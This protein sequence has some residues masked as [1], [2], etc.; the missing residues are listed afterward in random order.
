MGV[1]VVPD[2]TLA[3]VRTAVRGSLALLSVHRLFPLP[4]E[5]SRPEERRTLPASDDLTVVE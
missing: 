3:D 2:R 4:P 5:G 1:T